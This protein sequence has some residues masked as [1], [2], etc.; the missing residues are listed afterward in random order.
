VSFSRITLLHEV[1][2]YVIITISLRNSEHKFRLFNLTEISHLCVSFPPDTAHS[3][4]AKSVTMPRTS[5]LKGLCDWCN[6]KSV[7]LKQT[8]K[9]TEQ[10]L[11][12]SIVNTCLKL[13]L[14]QAVIRYHYTDT[15]TIIIRILN[16]KMTPSHL[17]IMS[18]HPTWRAAYIKL[19]CSTS[20]TAHNGQCIH[21]NQLIPDTH[22]SIWCADGRPTL[23]YQTNR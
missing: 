10:Y 6:E 19:R 18:Q 17:N 14:P 13:I 23:R 16:E 15:V 1:S 2:K 5:F 22:P 4:N 11:P 20:H 3:S 12:S 21:M 9:Q 8:D 7:L